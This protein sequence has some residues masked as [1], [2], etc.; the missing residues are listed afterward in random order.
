LL[1]NGKIDRR[2]LP[3]PDQNRLESKK[4]YEAPRTAAE[5]AV[6]NVWRE[7]LKINKV[8]IHDNFFDLGGH[9]LLATQVISRMRDALKIDLPLRILFETPTIEG[10]AQKLQNRIDQRDVTQI[11]RIGSVAREQHIVQVTR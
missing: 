7:V 2:A 10:L 6:A 4:I 3:A 5:V 11:E 8:G 9:S 1:P